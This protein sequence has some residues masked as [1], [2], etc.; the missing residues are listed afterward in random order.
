VRFQPTILILLALGAARDSNAQSDVLRRAMR[1]ELTRSMQSLHLDTLPTPYFIAYR[2]D[3]TDEIDVAASR[4]SVLHSGRSHGRILTVEVRVGDYAFDNTNFLAMPTAG[5]R[6]FRGFGGLAELPLDDDY[7]ALRRQLWLATDAAYK[8]AVELY[9]R[10]RASRAATPSLSATDLPD[11]S[12]EDVTTTTDSIPA[13]A[14]TLGEVVSLARRLSAVL[15]T[16]PEIERSEVS[17][18]MQTLRTLYLNSEGTSFTRSLPSSALR[19][20]AMTRAADGMQIGD[21]FTTRAASFGDLPSADSLSSRIRAL[22]SRLDVQRR[23]AR[24]DVYHGPIL[25]EGEAAAQVFGDVIGSQLLA[26]RRPAS[27]NPVFEQ[28]VAQQESPFLDEVG[29]LVLP[30]FLSVTDN[31]SLQTYAGQFVGGFRVDDDGVRTRE[32]LVV[33]HGILKSLLSTRVP[34]RGVPRSSGNRR[35]GEP[36]VSTL[37][38]T[39]D[40]G[41]SREGLRHR[42]LARIAARGVPYGIIVRHIGDAGVAASDNPFAVFAAMEGPS[43]SSPSFPASEVVRVYPDGHEEPIRGA[44]VSDISIGSFRD[45]AAASRAQ[46]VYGARS[47]SDEIMLDL[48]GFFGFRAM[49]EY[50]STYVVPDLLFDEGSV[51]ASSAQTSP[52]P[53]VPPPWAN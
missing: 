30:R 53:V 11:F 27:D 26:A 16:L 15:G 44:M 1:D 6:L 42:L 49:L 46:T 39:S 10:K 50:A 9:S 13:L 29:A 22:A 18:S 48:P 47:G 43:G 41:L 17:V 37:I 7:D 32:T 40:S 23:A 34:V 35:G 25:F 5:G 51:K 45:L 21:A 24:A 33:D 36:V 31:P 12:R 28:F 52:L 38:V 3:E 2:I 8:Q 20:E 19:V 14:A 4:S